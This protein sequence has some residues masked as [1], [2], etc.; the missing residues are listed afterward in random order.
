MKFFRYFLADGKQFLKL[1]GEDYEP[2]VGELKGRFRE[3]DVKFD[4]NPAPKI[5]WL[6]IDGK[7]IPWSYLDTYK[8]IVATKGSNWAKL[9][10]ND[11]SFDD[12]GYYTFFAENVQQRKEKIFHLKVKGIF[13]FNE[14]T[15]SA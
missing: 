2:Y 13:I 11:L 5:G 12:F 7:E 8:K 4:G 6:G 14:P 15:T 1:W 3:F 10:I 9:R